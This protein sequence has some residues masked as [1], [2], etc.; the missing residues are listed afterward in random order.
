MR[1][2]W[3]PLKYDID[4]KKLERQLYIGTKWQIYEMDDGSKS[5]LALKDLAEKWIEK[6]FL[7]STVFRI[8][9]FGSQTIYALNITG[10]AFL[11]PLNDRTYPESL[12][13]ALAFAHA[14]RHTRTIDGES[15]L[16]DAIYIEKLSLLLPTWS[17]S[18]Q[19]NDAQVL[20]EWL[21]SGVNISTDSFKRLSS[22]IS[23][24]DKESLRQ[25]ICTAGLMCHVEENDPSDNS[26]II[27][28]K[29]PFS[30]PG[31]P[32]LETFFN[33][34][35]IDIVIHQERYKKLGID[36]PSAVILYGPPGCGKTFAAEKLVDYLDW[37][38]YVINSGSIGSPYIHDTSKKIN[39]IFNKAMEDA[40]SI[41]LID[42]MEAYVSN[43]DDDNSGS[44]SH[45]EEVGE[46]LRL[47][48]KA[49][50][51]KVL[52]IGM[53]NYLDM[54]DPAIKRRGRFEHLVEV[55]MPSEEEVRALVGSLLNKIPTDNGLDLEPLIK[56]M[57]EKP[58]SDCS[59]AIR[60]AAR[61]AA[62]TGKDSIDQDSLNAAL[63]VVSKDDEEEERKI[64]F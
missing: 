35:I 26:P 47:I 16:H 36:F 49:V 63:G 42:E 10:E 28:E 44:K 2:S 31:R 12:N 54:I 53:T 4:G 48:P 38:C 56:Q 5:I 64:G 40:P 6:G 17:V 58:L 30:L 50:E 34:Y 27:Q 43:R 52:I 61:I 11:F 24:L 14:M 1:D 45:I 57:T 8:I 55:G 3:L 51:S 37:P 15:P 23:W 9:N 22:F 19:K 21:T 39:E 18:E 32:A 41:V 29:E 13:D 60:E 59:S 46:F 33:D 20:G 7:D 25:V 62:K